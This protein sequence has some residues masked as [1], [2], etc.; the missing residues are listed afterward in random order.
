MRVYG[1]RISYYTGKLENY[2]RY[3]GIDYAMLPTV[4]H[5]REIR[6]GAGAVQ[7]PVAQLDDGRWISDTTPILAWFEAGQPG[8]T[9]YPDDPA[10]RFAALLLEDYADEW[11]WRSAMHYRW[12]YLQDRQHASGVLADELLVGRR[13]PRFVK[14]FLITRRQLGGFVRGD[15]VTPATREHVEAGYFTAL[16]QLEAVFAER[17]FLLGDAPSIADFGFVG[18]MLRHFSQDPTSA[19][20]MRNRASGVYEWVARMW[21]RRASAEPARWVAAIDAPLS[22]LLTEACETHLV[23][24]AANAVAFAAGRGRYDQEIQGCHYRSVPCSRY[25]VWCLEELRRAWEALDETARATLRPHLAEPHAAVL[26]SGEPAAESGYDV[27]RRAPFNRAINV[28]GTG[29]PR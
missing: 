26:W 2:L 11:L 4:P 18:P 5:Y 17:P 19:E 21:N 8:P 25:R 10:L 27:E 15:G 22:A 12:S 29:V 6:A 23:Q 13:Q 16:D 28:F 3:R 20:I 14:R 7:H 1:S 24:L 9:I